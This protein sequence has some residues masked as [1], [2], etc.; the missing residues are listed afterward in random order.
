MIRVN[1]TEISEA[2]IAEEMQYHSAESQREAMLK[3]AEAL[4]IS[5]L[6]RQRAK[7]LELLDGDLPEDEDHFSQALFDR[8]LDYPKASNEDCLQYFKQNPAKFFSSPLIEARHILIAAD[9]REVEASLSAKD[10]AQ[11]LLEQLQE[12]ISQFDVLAKTYSACTSKETGGQLGQLSKGQTV[13][14]FERQ[15]FQCRPGLLAAPIETR[16]GYHIVQIDHVVEGQALPF[17]AVEERIR[18]YLDEK[19]RRKAIAQYIEQLISTADIEG[20]DFNV[21]DSPLMN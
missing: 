2:K 1:Q 15:L 9:P 7:E 6:L 20:F 16:Y 10:K 19:V 3:A 8:E 14:E 5:E 11:Q 21:S 18:H 17:D 12:D 4:L 13:A